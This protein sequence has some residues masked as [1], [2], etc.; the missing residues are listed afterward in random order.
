MDKKTAEEKMSQLESY[1]AKHSLWQFNSRGWDRE[2]QN[3]HILGKTKQLLCGE[4]ARENDSSADKYYWSEAKLL[5]DA[6][7]RYFHYFAHACIFGVKHIVM[8][9]AS[10]RK[11]NRLRIIYIFSDKIE[12]LSTTFTYKSSIALP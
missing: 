4:K 11:T 9:A 10:G 7:Y 8:L 12:F 2:L 5:V 6:F 1:I 3:E